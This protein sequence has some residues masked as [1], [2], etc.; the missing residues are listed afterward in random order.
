MDE[1]KRSSLMDSMKSTK[2]FALNENDVKTTQK[3]YDGVKIQN[4]V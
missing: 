1:E 4:F 2:Q 3:R